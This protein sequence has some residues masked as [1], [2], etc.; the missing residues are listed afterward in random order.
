M[1]NAAKQ[2]SG[3]W[4]LPMAAKAAIALGA[5]VFAAGAVN[6]VR[7]NQDW[8][9]ARSNAVPVSVYVTNYEESLDP[10]DKGEGVIAMASRYHLVGTYENASGSKSVVVLDESYSHDRSDDASAVTAY[11]QI[12]QSR[13]VYLNKAT[14]GASGKHL[15]VSVPDFDGSFL[16]VTAAGLVTVLLGAGVLLYD[17]RKS[18]SA[19]NA[20]R[21]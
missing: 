14:F 1:K 13:D 4:V 15:E 10:M 6:G 11:D 17:G 9:D 20:A 5:L 3:A 16:V 7:Q 12:G 8:Y 2:H 19:A 18:G 21:C